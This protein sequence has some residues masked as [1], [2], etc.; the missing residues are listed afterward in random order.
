[1]TGFIPRI[2]FVVVIAS[3]LGFPRGSAVKTPPAVPKTQGTRVLWLGWE[4]ALEEGMATHF[5]ILARISHGQGSLVSY[6]PWGHK[7]L[8]TT[9]ATEHSCTHVA[10]H[11]S[12]A[13]QLS[14]FAEAQEVSWDRVLLVLE[15]GKPQAN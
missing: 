14:Q 2:V 6:G 1:M 8:D 15:P 12:K 5:S 3:P 11:L 10:L 4:D 7:E 9:E 13:E